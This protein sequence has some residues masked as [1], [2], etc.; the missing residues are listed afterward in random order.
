[1]TAVLLT[2]RNVADATG[3]SELTIRKAINEGALPAK[4]IG[5]SV[6][7][8]PVDLDAWVEALESVIN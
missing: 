8:R 3:L 1:M 7:I 5:K 2:V 4:R 6:R